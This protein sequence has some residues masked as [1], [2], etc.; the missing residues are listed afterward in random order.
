MLNHNIKC[1]LEAD[2]I[3]NE[4]MAYIKGSLKYVVDFF[5]PRRKVRRETTE[6]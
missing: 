6:R 4:N 2:D 1:L 5:G 3:D